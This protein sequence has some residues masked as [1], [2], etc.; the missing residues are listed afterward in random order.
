VAVAAFVGTRS[1]SLDLSAGRWLFLT[2]PAKKQQLV[3][4]K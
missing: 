1:V 3:V 4:V 2:T